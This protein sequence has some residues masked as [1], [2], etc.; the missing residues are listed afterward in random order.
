MAQ[1]IDHWLSLFSKGYTNSDFASASYD[2]TIESV[3]T[4]KAAMHFNGDFFA[5]SVH[6]AYPNTKLGIFPLSMPTAIEDCIS[7]NTASVGFVA[8]KNSK[9]IDAIK[10]VFQLWSTPAYA[11]LYFATRFGF[12]AFKGVDG[13]N[14]PDYIVNLNNNY[15]KPGKVRTEFNDFLG[16]DKNPAMD[17]LWVEYI[18]AANRG[19][20][21]GAQILQNYQPRHEQYMKENRQPG[22]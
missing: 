9:N 4:G 22:F 3:G 14:V 20:I 16:I 1:V 6:E 17:Y 11:N 15:I 10:K 5:A 7:A 19:N 21:T 18:N 2:N 8:N 13:G 12:P